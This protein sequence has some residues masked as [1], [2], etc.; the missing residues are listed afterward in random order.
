[1]ES[2]LTFFR[3]SGWLVIATVASGVFMTATQIVASRWM[4]PGEYGLWFTLLRV[5]LFMSIPSAGLQIIFAQ[6]TAAAIAPHQHHQ[7]ARTVRATLKAT[8]I[9]WL[10]VAVAAFAGTPYWMGLLKIS[11]P[12]AWHFTLLIGLASLWFPLVRGV[13]QGQQHFLGLGWVLILDGIGRFG[14]VW[15]ILAFGGEA[16]GGMAG[17]LLGTGVA[18]ALGGWLLRRLLIE[19]GEPMDWRPWFRKTVP[20]TIAMGG[21]QFMMIFDVPFVR[22]VFPADQTAT[23]YMPAALIGL[24]LITFLLPMSAVMFPKI[25]RSAALTQHTHALEHAFVATASMGVAAACACVLFPKLPL[26]IIY[27][28]KPEYWAAA[29]LVPWFTWCLLPLMLANVLIANLLARERFGIAWPVGAIALAYALTLLLAK[30]WLLSLDPTVAFRTVLQ[31]LGGYGVLQL[32]AS[33]WFT[34][35]S[36]VPAS[37]AAA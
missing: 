17:A 3:Q 7:L 1:M 16:A 5:Y 34:L 9:F 18:I 21:I 12:A 8:F 23:G 24:A 25:V 32:L 6:Q 15:I 2:R 4:E 35:R 22:S 20:L 27:F 29:P 28:G 31:I 19:P 13:L 33:A 11:R 10:L 37:A 26:Q 30:P 14:L 36:R